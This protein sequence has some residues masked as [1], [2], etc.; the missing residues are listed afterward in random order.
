MCFEYNMY[1][2]VNF[3]NTFYKTIVLVYLKL[4]EKKVVLDPSV[5]PAQQQKDADLDIKIA[6][7]TKDTEHRKLFF[8]AIL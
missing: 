7:R 8:N 5:T 2:G 1:F 3:L 4:Q 6:E